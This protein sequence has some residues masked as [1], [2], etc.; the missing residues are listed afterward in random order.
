ML[1]VISRTRNRLI[2]TILAVVALCVPAQAHTHG[3]DH[4]LHIHN[5]LE[6]ERYIDVWRGLSFMVVE[7]AELVTDS[8]YFQRISWQDPHAGARIHWIIIPNPRLSPY[9]LLFAA[10]S[11]ATMGRMGGWRVTDSHGTSD[12][13]LA[14]S[15][16]SQQT[17]AAFTFLIVHNN[18]LVYLHAYNFHPDEFDRI[19]QAA[20]ALDLSI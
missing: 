1:V 3:H 20:E 8:D 17:Q 13:S 6:F 5:P 16:N 12:H 18:Y 10:H 2:I 14:I 9:D 11:M 7:G 19:F 4:G 15:L